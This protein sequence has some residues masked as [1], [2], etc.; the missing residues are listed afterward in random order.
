MKRVKRS[1]KEVA[2]K[3]IMEE[4]VV[5]GVKYCF[6]LPGEVEDRKEAVEVSNEKKEEEEEGEGEEVGEELLI[7]DLW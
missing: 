7:G 4:E 5:G 2:R 1:A 6:A 3:S